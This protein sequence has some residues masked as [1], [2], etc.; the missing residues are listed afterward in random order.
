MARE[1]LTGHNDEESSVLLAPANTEG[2]RTTVYEDDDAAALGNDITAI[3]SRPLA[4]RDEGLG[5]RR[6]GL[7]VVTLVLFL[8]SVLLSCI[9][10]IVPSYLGAD[11][12]SDWKIAVLFASKAVVQLLANPIVGA[13]TGR[14]GTRVVLMAGTVVMI[15]SS[16]GFAFGTT[17][18]TLLVARA[19]QG[20]GSACSGCA[21]LTQVAQMFPED[22]LLGPSMAT[23]TMGI[24]IGVIVG[25]PFGGIVYTY[26]GNQWPFFILAIAGAVSLLIQFGLLTRRSLSQRLHRSSLAAELEASVH[27]PTSMLT[28]LTNR[29]IRRGAV[30]LVV[31]NAVIASIEPAFPLWAKRLFGSSPDTV[32]L[33]FLAA[34]L[35]YLAGTGFAG[36]LAFRLGRKTLAVA[37]MFMSSLS[38]G[39]LVWPGP[40][41]TIL[42]SIPA[43]VGIGFAIGVCEASTNPIMATI[44][45]TCYTNAESTVF[46]IVDM[47]FAFGF[48]AGPLLAAAIYA[49]NIPFM[50]VCAAMAGCTFLAGLYVSTI[51][52]R[53]CT[54]AKMDHIVYEGD[55]DT[56]ALL[57]SQ[58]GGA[59][60]S[61]TTSPMSVE[62]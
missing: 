10:P 23:A 57:K 2:G 45:D 6:V 30:A 9:I 33:V 15:G 47:C 48:A 24:G 58:P 1:K 35:S 59:Y 37:S 54:K 44:A 34:S 53:Y 49:F 20:I 55:D 61:L 4:P 26:A 22:E 31:Q 42:E 43:L 18:E 40:R 50:Y 62:G 21:G 25:P 17:F 11:G 12:T 56:V 16:V 27:P 29:N 3:N 36:G 14:I 32:G 8:D 51:D 13:V 7:A 19:I 60:N 5:A 52:N 28:L 46:A 38:I 41:T 39:F